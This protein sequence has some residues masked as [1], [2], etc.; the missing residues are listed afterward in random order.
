MQKGGAVVVGDKVCADTLALHQRQNIV[1][2]VRDSRLEFDDSNEMG[3]RR[4][5]EPLAVECAV[6][7]DVGG[8]GQMEVGRREQTAITG[9]IKGAVPR[10]VARDD[11]HTHSMRQIRKEKSSPEPANAR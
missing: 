2:I 4:L 7:G 11:L 10:R 6:E 1:V 9:S 8:A 5:Y 3:P